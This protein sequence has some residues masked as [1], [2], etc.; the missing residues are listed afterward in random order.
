M[1]RRTFIAAILVWTTAATVNAQLLR[2][3]LRGPEP[4]S[5]AYIGEPY[6]VGRWTVQL[7]PGANPSILGN[8]GF[9][10]SEK[11]GRVLF[12]AFQSEPLRTGLREVLGRPQT[13]TVYFL[14]TGDQPLD[15]QLFASSPIPTAIIPTRDPIAQGKLLTDWWVNYTRQANRIDRPVDYPDVVDNYLLA[16]L[17]RRLNLPPASEIPPSP[18][19]QLADSLLGSLTGGAPKLP[20]T[21][22][23]DEQFDREI[24]LLLGSDSLR[25]QMQTE[26][27]RRRTQPPEVADQPLPQTLNFSAKAPQPAGEVAIEPIANHVPAECFYM[28]FGSFVN[29]QWFR[30]TMDRWSGDL[31]NLVS[32]RGMDLGIT[33][34]VERQLSLKESLLAPILGPAVIADVAM[35]GDDVFFREGATV[36]FLFQARN[37]MALNTDFSQQRAAMLAREPGCTEQT[38]DIAGHKVLFLS[39]PDN[40]VRS[41]YA[42]DGDFHFVTNSRRLVERFYAAAAGKESLGA[43]AEF[44]YARSRMPSNRDYTVFAYLSSA[45]FRNLT[46]PQYQIEMARRERS[47]AEIDMALVAQLAAHFEGREAKTLD[48]LI[49]ADYLPE[50]FGQRADGSRLEIDDRGQLVDS[51]RGARGS[52][53]PTADITFEQTTPT[54]ARHYDDFVAWFQSKWSQIDPVVAGIRRE[55]SKLREPGVERII[56]DAELT[57]MAAKN[58]ETIATAL[59]PISKQRLAAVPG[60]VVSGEVVLS[61]NLLASKGLAAP[62][63]AYRLFGALRDG[64]PEAL[65]AQ[66]AGRGAPTPAQGPTISLGGPGG[67]GGPLNGPLGAAINSA[68]GAA[69]QGAPILSPFSYLPPFYFGAY[70][71]PAVFSWFGVGDVPLDAAGYGRSASSGL[72]QRRVGKFTTASM[73][74]ETLEA[75]TAQFRFVD[76]PRPAQAWVHAGDISRSKLASTINSLFYAVSK[77]AAVGNVRFLQSL[78]TQLRVPSEDGLKVAEQLTD[79]KLVDPL[80]GQYKLDQRP[81]SPATWVSTSLPADRMRLID[82]L[83]EAAAS[84]YTAPILTW[85]RGLD[86]DVAVDNQILSLHAEVEMQQNPTA[87]AP[88]PTQPNGAP[89]SRPAPNGSTPKPSTPPNS[90]TPPPPPTPAPPKTEEIPPPPNP[91]N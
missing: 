7:P 35:I 5:E 76:A 83:F 72:W 84:D 82:G 68:L 71:T 55:P 14:F 74:R 69:G 67:R 24:G 9:S 62:Q 89:A 28:R 53:A 65:G 1:P 59:G 6:G 77:N 44:R 31:A 42:V 73:Q 11:N 13:A 51:L 41:F 10:L 46:G 25:S 43:S 8:S 64:V 80:G 81:G 34:R 33:P 4:S 78:A 60:D 86:A 54:E 87:A 29:Y 75:V 12:A 70:P 91:R 37:S 15:L 22:T 52:F 63:G 90:G 30:H 18:M 57:P 79:A 66:P 23:G 56:V 88:K 49:R 47:V 3:R 27:L 40:R 48:D 20:G 61:G 36:G 17:A 32:R 50:G 45:F 19:R 85:L 39:T 58:Y 2:G 38:I 26:V 16:T 21:S